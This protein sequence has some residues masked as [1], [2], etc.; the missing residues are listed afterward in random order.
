[1]PGYPKI[2]I[3]FYSQKNNSPRHEVST[4]THVGL[5]R[6]QFTFCI[7]FSYYG[8]VLSVGTD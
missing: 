8:V 6:F 3:I 4:I 1:M 7:L 5:E 2:S